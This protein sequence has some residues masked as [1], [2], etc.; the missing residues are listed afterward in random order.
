MGYHRRVSRSSE[1][2][3]PPDLKMQR[4]ADVTRT[5]R[6]SGD[7]VRGLLARNCGL[8]ETELRSRENK[9]S[10]LFT[11]A[12]SFL[13]VPPIC[14][15]QPKDKGRGAQGSIKS[16]SSGVQSWAEK[17]KEYSHPPLSEVSLSELSVTRCQSWSKNIKWTIPEI[18]NS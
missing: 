11:S 9:T 1:M 16:H 13:P 10:G 6:G 7:C 3:P 12:T 17:D 2:L 18:N 8:R 14:G 15:P 5:V 4:E